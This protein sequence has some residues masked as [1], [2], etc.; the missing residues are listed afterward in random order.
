MTPEYIVGYTDFY[1]K[2]SSIQI[3]PFNIT[4]LFVGFI[5][6]LIPW[7]IDRARKP[8]LLI[9]KAD[10][11]DLNLQ[12]GKFRSLNLKIVNKR[13]TGVKRFFN[14]T[15]TQLRCQLIFL[16]F[17][18]RAE[19]FE[20]KIIARWNTTREPLTPDYKQ[21]DIGLALTNPR[22]VVA[23]GEIATISILIKKEGIDSC[24]PFNNE[25]YLSPN[26]SK[27]EWEI[28]DKKFIVRALLQSAESDEITADFLVLNKSN[29][30][31]FKISKKL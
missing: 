23:P 3:L 17:E 19:I 7:L 18:S 12:Q 30:S 20:D 26:F 4:E 10:P 21:V 31:Q 11:S 13:K 8:E 28:S 5:L 9:N 14:Q 1:K 25:S 24:Y 22:E 16:D 27:K 29:L 6:G 15:A 2:V